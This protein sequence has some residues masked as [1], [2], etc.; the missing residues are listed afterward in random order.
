MRARAW[1]PA[2]RAAQAALVFVPLASLGAL[3][4]GCDRPSGGA[5]PA[6]SASGA[7]V[8][9]LL[10]ATPP[11]S[12][13]LTVDASPAVSVGSAAAAPPRVTV[14]NIGI[15]IGGGP[16]DPATK[17][18]IA[19]GV[20]PH[21]DE[22]RGCWTKVD[23]PARG[24]DFGVDLL[25]PAQGGR[26]FVSHPRTSLH[27]DAFQDCVVSVFSTIEFGPPRFG[28]T[29]VSYALRFTPTP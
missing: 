14:Q 23:D 18:P 29:A 12:A 10:A 2:R 7:P 21:L 15:H 13:P 22:L 25:V 28:K 1:G 9:S 26:A 3:S 24:G 4:A 20:S 5:A 19:D 16:N 17:A 6:S 11:P 27:P 8:P